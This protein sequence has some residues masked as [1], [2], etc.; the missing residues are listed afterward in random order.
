MTLR[1]TLLIDAAGVRNAATLQEYSAKRARVNETKC[2][3]TAEQ[4]QP[5]ARPD[6]TA[7]RIHPPRQ[8]TRANPSTRPDSGESRLPGPGSNSSKLRTIVLW[9]AFEPPDL[10]VL[11]S[12]ER[13]AR[14]SACSM[15]SAGKVR[16]RVPVAWRRNS[17]EAGARKVRRTSSLE[18]IFLRA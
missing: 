16:T 4:H 7:S 11:S 14:E 12:A 10:S 15:R 17:P 5:L 1:V 18:Q 9:R 8:K 3:E 13:Q 2:Q 6:A